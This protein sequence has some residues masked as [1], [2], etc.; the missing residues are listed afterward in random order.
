MTPA[1]IVPIRKWVNDLTN[2]SCMNPRSGVPQPAWVE[3]DV[4]LAG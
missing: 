4:F 3:L 2:Y 1:R